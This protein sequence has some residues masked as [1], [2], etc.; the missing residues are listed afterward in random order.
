M[1]PFRLIFVNWCIL[2]VVGDV[3]EELASR[4][5]LHHQEKIL[6]GLDDLVHLDQ[7]GVPDQLKDVDLSAHSL[8]VRDV[9]N[10]LLL[11]DLD[12]HSLACE[13]VGCELHLAEGPLP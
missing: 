11:E 1:P 2:L 13:I 6:G 12:G 4:A 5:I 10:L 7:I 9:H 8:D 3:V